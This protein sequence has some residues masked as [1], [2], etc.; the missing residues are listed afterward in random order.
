MKSSR[1][2]KTPYEIIR[3]KRPNISHIRVFGSRAYVRKR[4]EVRCGK[5]Y[6]QALP[7]TLVSFSRG[8]VY[9]VL[10]NGNNAVVESQDVK[11]VKNAGA[12]QHHDIDCDVI[13][14][15]LS[16]DSVIIDD[17]VSR[18]E[19]EGDESEQETDSIIYVT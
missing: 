15:D 8:E 5:L 6:S 10:L 7:G 19:R 9:R 12:A 17:I 14:Y 2:R 1:E 4:K 11:I 18:V 16:E 3:D 13:E